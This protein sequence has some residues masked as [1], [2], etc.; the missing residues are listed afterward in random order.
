MGRIFRSVRPVLVAASFAT[1]FVAVNSG[2]ATATVPAVCDDVTLTSDLAIT[3]GDITTGTTTISAAVNTQ[4]DEIVAELDA[5]HT[6]LMAEMA[7]IDE[8]LQDAFGLLGASDTNDATL[9]TSISAKGVDKASQ[10]AVTLNDQ[11][12]QATQAQ[13]MASG[14]LTYQNGNNCQITS[15]EAGASSMSNSVELEED[16]YNSYIANAESPVLATGTSV[17]TGI[18]SAS[19][20]SPCGGAV[21]GSTWAPAGVPSDEYSPRPVASRIHDIA[22]AA[23]G[24]MGSSETGNASD[25]GKQLTGAT[26]TTPATHLDVDA[27]TLSDLHTFNDTEKQAHNLLSIYLA[28][29]PGQPVSNNSTFKSN[30]AVYDPAYVA[31]QEKLAVYNLAN[32]AIVHNSSYHS[33]VNSG[34]ANSVSAI[35][36]AAGFAPSKYVFNGQVSPKALDEAMYIQPAEDPN[37]AKNFHAMGNQPLLAFI[38]NE[39]LLLNRIE[40]KRYIQEMEVSEVQSEQLNLQQRTFDFNQFQ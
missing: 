2:P 16:S 28:G 30:T 19:T 35:F 12:D 24:F 31:H 25:D 7:G 37:F 27:L 21:N 36:Q 9:Q 10:D 22:K 17:Y 11:A 3:D 5:D 34:A 39:M 1:V 20:C 4:G 14:G 38:A 32:R 26:A 33:A 23:K 6:A 29:Q 13:T 18:P 40:Y 15:D 8:D